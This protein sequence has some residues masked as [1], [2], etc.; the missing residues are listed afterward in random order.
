MQPGFG[1]S[2]LVEQKARRARDSRLLGRDV[3]RQSN[4][5]TQ[6]VGRHVGS[7]KLGTWEEREEAEFWPALRD[8][9]ADVLRRFEIEGKEDCEV[10][11]EQ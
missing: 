1:G 7:S 3:V 11:A 2:G 6:T 10:G 8:G 4:Q 5:G 9:S